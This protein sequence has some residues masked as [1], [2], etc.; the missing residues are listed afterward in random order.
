MSI[1]KLSKP[2]ADRKIQ[3]EIN[4]TVNAIDS[5]KKQMALESQYIDTDTATPSRS[6]SNPRPSIKLSKLVSPKSEIADDAP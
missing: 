3:S 4:S 2:H 6:T 1:N 5:K